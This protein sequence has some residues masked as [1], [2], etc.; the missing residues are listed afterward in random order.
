MY[1]INI[2]NNNHDINNVVNNNNSNDSENRNINISNSENNGI[3]INY[4]MN[5]SVGKNRVNISNFLN[6]EWYKY[7]CNV[8]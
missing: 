5:W 2:N 8:V 1:I 3:I 6:N 7:I 4:I